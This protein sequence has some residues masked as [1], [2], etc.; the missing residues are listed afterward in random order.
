MGSRKTNLKRRKMIKWI[1][2]NIYGKIRNEKH[3][4]IAIGGVCFCLEF[5]C[6][7]KRGVNPGGLDGLLRSSEVL[8]SRPVPN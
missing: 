8:G 1:V 6:M 3:D 5:R 7:D 2:D 4:S